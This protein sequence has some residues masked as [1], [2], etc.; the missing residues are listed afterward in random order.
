MK[1]WNGQALRV[2]ACQRSDMR[3]LEYA[4]EAMH[5]Q[6][7]TNG[8]TDGSWELTQRQDERRGRLSHEIDRMF[9]TFRHLLNNLINAGQE[10]AQR[11][12]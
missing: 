12:R 7:P 2:D 3:T 11:W 9:G 10:D 6:R 5:R 1:R 4:D 8:R